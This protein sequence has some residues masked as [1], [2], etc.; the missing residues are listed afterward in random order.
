MELGSSGTVTY[1]PPWVSNSDSLHFAHL[2]VEGMNVGIVTGAG[3]DFNLGV[4]VVVIP[5]FRPDLGV[6]RS[7]RLRGGLSEGG[8]EGPLDRTLVTSSELSDIRSGVRGMTTPS[9]S[10]SLSLV[11]ED[12]DKLVLR[13]PDALGN[14]DECRLKV[15]DSS[16]SPPD[17]GELD[18]L[19]VDEVESFNPGVCGEERDVRRNL[20]FISSIASAVGLEDAGLLVRLRVGVEYLA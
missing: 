9:A 5:S 19:T 17:G 14:R 1:L 20:F 4:R 12:E 18:S 6:K 8:V 7:S 2:A 13:L 11:K 15:G 10:F 16:P 3:D